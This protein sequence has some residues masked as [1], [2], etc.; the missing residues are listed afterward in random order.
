MV[1]AWHSRFWSF[2]STGNTFAMEQSAWVR[3]PSLSIPFASPGDQNQTLSLIIDEFIVV[4]NF[5]GLGLEVGVCK[6]INDDEDKCSKEKLCC[7]APH[8]GKADTK[9]CCWRGIESKV[10]TENPSSWLEPL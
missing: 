10:P 5:F 7:H 8:K 1:K 2:S 6:D 9:L 4:C 3:V